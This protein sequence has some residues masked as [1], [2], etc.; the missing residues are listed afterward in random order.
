M[1]DFT[2]NVCGKIIIY[3]EVSCRSLKGVG[4]LAHLVVVIY[5]LC[6]CGVCVCHYIVPYTE[7]V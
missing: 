1:G 5:M 4:H 7:E 2:W 3:T 6:V